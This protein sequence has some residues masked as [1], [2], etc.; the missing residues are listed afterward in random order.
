MLDFAGLKKTRCI[1]SKL[2]TRTTCALADALF[3][4]PRRTRIVFEGLEN[5]PDEPAVI[6]PN[7]THKFDFLPIRSQLLTKHG[8]EM[9]T[10][11]KARDYQSGAMALFFDQTGNIPLV[12][13]GYIIA[14]DF[15][16]VHGRKPTEDEYRS[17]RA[18][19]DEVGPQP[20][21][22]VFRTLFETSRDV[23]GLPFD[24]TGSYDE[25]MRGIYATF[26]DETLGLA[27][28]VRD[29]GYHQ[30]IYPQGATSSQLT[31]GKTGAVQAALALDLPIVPVGMSGCREVFVGDSPLARGGEV[32]IRFGEPV[33]VAGAID[34]VRAF[35]PDWETEH[36]EVL[37]TL[38]DD[39]MHRIADLVEP[40]YSW[41]DDAFSDGKRGIKRFF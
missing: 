23:L 10:W 28:R 12:S 4:V 15:K 14:A 41:A 16:A 39:L 3:L 9:A 6:A 37:R 30:Q 19:V 7:H 33:S 21:G 27:G 18:W 26:M 11:I 38:T 34:D 22:E 1:P 36:D 25:N 20:A 24:A 31:P 17:L 13:R 32:I 8:I 2:W 35:Q 29:A 40:H 5:I